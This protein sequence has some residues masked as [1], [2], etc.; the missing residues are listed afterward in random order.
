VRGTP[1]AH[2]YVL[3]TNENTEKACDGVPIFSVFGLSSAEN[4]T[5]GAR[6]D[7]TEP[8]RRAQNPDSRPVEGRLTSRASIPNPA[9]LAVGRNQPALAVLN[10]DD[11]RGIC[12][13]AFSATHAKKVGMSSGDSDAEETL[14]ASIDQARG[15]KPIGHPSIIARGDAR[16]ETHHRPGRWHALGAYFGPRRRG[17]RGVQRDRAKHREGQDRRIPDLRQKAGEV[18][19]GRSSYLPG[20]GRPV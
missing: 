19:R 9:H 4:G 13:A 14:H 11:W 3:K 15:T 7:G 2:P 6:H 20:R 8:S 5:P 10:Q 1:H 12:P 17:P 16:A 18:L